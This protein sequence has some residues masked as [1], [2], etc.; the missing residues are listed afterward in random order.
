[1]KTIGIVSKPGKVETAAVAAR[2]KEKYP[3]YTILVEEHLGKLTGWPHVSSEELGWRSDLVVVLGGDGTLIHAARALKGRAVPIVG[4]NLGSLG[5]L[6]EITEDEMLPVLH[7]ALRGKARVES[8]MKLKCRLYRGEALLL[9]DEVLN[10]IVIARNAFAR[11]VDLKTWSGGA[12]VAQFKS[13]GLIFATPTGSTAYS[14]SAGGPIVHPSVDAVILTPISPHALTQRP[15]VVP[16]DQVIRVE[17]AAE[18]SDVYVSIDGKSGQPLLHGD[19]IEVERSP[20]RA[21][22]VCKEDRDY[23]AVLRT[24]LRWGER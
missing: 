21:F 12:F 20:N 10:D 16:G 14:M 22:L 15:I 3:D 19:R 17:L 2:I 1:M 11:I 18:G 4:V 6:T 13:D 24:K 23:Y 9:E 8:R 7:L 5:F